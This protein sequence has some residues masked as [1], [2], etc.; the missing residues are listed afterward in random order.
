MHI[1]GEGREY[2]KKKI[3]MSLGGAEQNRWRDMQLLSITLIADLLN[4]TSASTCLLLKTSND[5]RLILYNLLMDD[6]LKEHE[7]KTHVR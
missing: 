2:L 7:S 6:L 4:A 1:M 5:H 3:S